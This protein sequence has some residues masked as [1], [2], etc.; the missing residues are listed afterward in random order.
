[1]IKLEI[2]SDLC[3]HLILIHGL[4]ECAISISLYL[5]IESKLNYM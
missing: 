2:I 5:H 1:M 3:L 4:P